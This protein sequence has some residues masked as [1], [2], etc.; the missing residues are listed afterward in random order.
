MKTEKFKWQAVV[1]KYAY[2]ETWR[3]VWQVLNSLMP[4]MVMWYL[5]Y[6]SL[7]VSWWLVLVLV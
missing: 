7:T 4:F 5:M 6:R 3:S 2:P 1:A